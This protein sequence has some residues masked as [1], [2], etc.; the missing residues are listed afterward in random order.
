MSI[1]PLS[2]QGMMTEHDEATV[3]KILLSAEGVQRAEVSR[4]DGQAVAQI[5]DEI[6]NVLVL[7][8]LL[9]K[10]GYRA[11]EIMM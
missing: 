4:E 2:V 5:D 6:T 11:V 10:A 7:A 3:K 1:V 8:D 9:T